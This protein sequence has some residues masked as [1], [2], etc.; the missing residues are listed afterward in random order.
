MNNFTL[1][2]LP[3]DGLLLIETK[4]Y[5][6]DRGFFMETYNE[7]GFREIGL[8]LDFVQDN[9]SRSRRGILRGLHFQKTHPQ[10]KLVCV[11][12]GE[13]FDV[14]VDLRKSSTTFG[15]WFGVNLSGDRGTL[16]YIPPGFA[17]GFYVLSDTAD[18]MYKCTDFYRPDD[19]GGLLWNDPAV[20]IAWPVCDVSYPVMTEKDKHYPVFADCFHYE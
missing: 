7:E 9:R 1:N 11:T 18:F 8:S 12:N 20:G 6:D 2:R 3:I 17:H 4:K 19:E 10:G 5:G 14:A 15:E 13:V 16:F